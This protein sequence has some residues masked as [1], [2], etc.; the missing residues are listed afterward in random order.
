MADAYQA[1]LDEAAR[2][3]RESRY[4]IAFVGAGMSAESGIPTF[5]GPGGLWTRFGEPD[6]RG[7]E[8]FLQDPKGWWENRLRGRSGGADRERAAGSEMGEAI[9]RAQPNPGHYALAALEE[10]GYIKA[11]VTQNV[12]N[13]HQVAGSRRVLEFHGNRTK[14]RCI[15]CLAR[16]PAADFPLEELPPRCPECGGIVKSDTVMFGEP[17][18]LDVLQE[19]REE[20]LRADLV[21]VIGTSAVVYPAAEIPLI[22]KRRGA[23]LVE[24]NP[25]ES[26]LSPI[27][28]VIIRL[29]SGQALPAICQRVLQGEG[30]ERGTR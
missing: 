22:A 17:I 15:R 8:R 9:A 19:S 18:P 12:D 20:A 2:L 23:R 14:L 3:L 25:L 27:C 10:H 24:V 13:L 1:E 6:P 5:R 26:A 28:D 11:V 29:P 4:A 16:F 21:L 7:Y 30:L